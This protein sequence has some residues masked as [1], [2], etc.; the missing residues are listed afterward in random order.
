MTMDDDRGER[1][2]HLIEENPEDYEAYRAYGDW[3]EQQGDP[4]GQLMALHRTRETLADRNKVDHLETKLEALFELHRDRWLGKLANVLPKPT[5][6]R[7]ARANAADVVW[8]W[9]FIYKVECKRFG[10]L[11]IDKFLDH[12]LAHPSGRF[13]VD[14]TTVWLEDPDAVI[15]VLAK[16]APL[17]LRRLSLGADANVAALWPR[18]SRLHELVICAREYGRIVLPELRRATF[19]IRRSEELQGIATAEWP[20]LESLRLHFET[21]HTASATQISAALARGNLPSLRSLSLACRIQL[22]D[23]LRD[24]RVQPLGKQLKELELRHFDAEV[25]SI[26]ANFDPP[27]EVL[28]VSDYDVEQARGVAKRVE[29]V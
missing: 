20:K 16:R 18:L 9:G 5:S 17:S 10:R 2:A 21:D 4:R 25:A 13:I 19:S 7:A 11:T 1:L 26:L 14:L 23:V 24:L 12:L 28:K 3:L 22:P 29:P 6:S 27:L 15:A 8:R